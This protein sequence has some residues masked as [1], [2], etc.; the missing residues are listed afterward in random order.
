VQLFKAMKVLLEN[1]DLY[2]TLKKNARKQVTI[3]YEQQYVWNEMLK[4]YK[5]LENV[6]NNNLW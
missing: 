5:R 3:C 1:K 6:V 2:D 4:E